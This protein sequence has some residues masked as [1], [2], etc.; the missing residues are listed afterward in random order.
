VVGVEI[1][2]AGKTRTDSSP[3]ARASS[4]VVNFIFFSFGPN[5][6]VRVALKVKIRR[7]KSGKGARLLTIQSKSGLR[8]EVN[9]V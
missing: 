9:V 5:W 6:R 2:V 1:P 7:R 4:R 3:N 8:G